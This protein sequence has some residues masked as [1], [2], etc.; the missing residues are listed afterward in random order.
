MSRSGLLACCTAVV[1]LAGCQQA[2]PQPAGTPSWLRTVSLRP[3]DFSADTTPTDRHASLIDVRSNWRGLSLCL[4]RELP[5]P[6][7]VTASPILAVPG[8]NTYADSVAEWFPAGVPSLTPLDQTDKCERQAFAAHGDR[9]LS[10]DRSRMTTGGGD[11]TM[12]VSAVLTLSDGRRMTD[13]DLRADVG[14][15]LVH[16]RVYGTQ[17]LPVAEEERLLSAVVGRARPLAGRT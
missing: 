11:D 13:D 16:V 12:R 7:G 17:T 15:L 1:A 6:R 9:I 4:G 2:S 3:T 14:H 10:F 5:Q 8:G